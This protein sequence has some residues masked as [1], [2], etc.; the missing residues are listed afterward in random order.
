MVHEST[1][2]LPATGSGPV[3]PAQQHQLLGCSSLTSS[4]AH[5]QLRALAP[6]SRPAIM[7][8][9]AHVWHASPTKRLSDNH[10]FQ[11]V[12]KVCQMIRRLSLHAISPHLRAR[13]GDNA[14]ARGLTACMMTGLPSKL[15]IMSPAWMMEYVK[16]LL[17]TRHSSAL[18]FK[19]KI[20]PCLNEPN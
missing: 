10:T 17:L 16:A 19:I 8:T 18:H 5:H 2:S 9:L 6:F 12:G 3:Q 20:S 15:I 13:C 7:M 11:S 14:A 1:C 4:R